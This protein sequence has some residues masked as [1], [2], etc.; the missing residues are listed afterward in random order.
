MTL[1]EYVAKYPN[2]N[3]L[4]LWKN[5]YSDERI[6]LKQDKILKEYLNHIIDSVN[7]NRDLILVQFREIYPVNGYL[8]YVIELSIEDNI[9][10]ISPYYGGSDSSMRGKLSIHNHNMDSTTYVDTIIDMKDHINAII[11]YKESV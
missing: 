6:I 11:N 7:T 9:Y 1:S 10:R 5:W 2:I 4:E 8:Y 3:K